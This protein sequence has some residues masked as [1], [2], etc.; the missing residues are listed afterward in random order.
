MNYFLKTAGGVWGTLFVN[1]RFPNRIKPYRLMLNI[2][3]VCVLLFFVVC[4][5]VIRDTFGFC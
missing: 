4:L 1:A 2:C 3:A 5:F